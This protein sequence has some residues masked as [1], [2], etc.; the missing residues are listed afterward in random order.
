MRRTETDK[1]DAWLA[2]GHL[3]QQAEGLTDR[4]VI[5]AIRMLLPLALRRHV[6]VLLDQNVKASETL[7]AI[8]MIYDYAGIAAAVSAGPL[9]DLSELG[10]TELDSLVGSLHKEQERRSTP[11]QVNVDVHPE[12][13]MAQ[14]P[15]Q[16][17]DTTDRTDR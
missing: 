16:V 14:E 8:K 12:P 11:E 5:V 6:D 17:Y 7:T 1:T 4:Q 10:R 13:V 2:L 15:T 3:Q 9:K